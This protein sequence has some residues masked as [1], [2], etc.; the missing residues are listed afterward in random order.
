[1]KLKNLCT[2]FF[3]LLASHTSAQEPVL[4]DSLPLPSVG[5][6]GTTVTAQIP[7][8]ATP[9]PTID[10]RWTV[11]DATGTQ[12]SSATVAQT[13]RVIGS[14]S[15]AYLQFLPVVAGQ[16][17][18]SISWPTWTGSKVFV[19]QI[20]EGAIQESTMYTLAASINRTATWTVGN[21]IIRTS[22]A[23]FETLLVEE[24][25]GGQYHIVVYDQRD[26]ISNF[27][28][29]GYHYWADDYSG[30]ESIMER[31]VPDGD[32]SRYNVQSNP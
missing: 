8:S 14:D 19:S 12:V 6:V 20:S 32:K 17:I 23:D 26:D 22:S 27:F 9:A 28:Q 21:A 13:T 4:T 11:L 3:L 15:Y 1:M 16:T 30:V 5:V 10:H 18:L 24:F 2:L 31:A 7:L 29:K 25:I